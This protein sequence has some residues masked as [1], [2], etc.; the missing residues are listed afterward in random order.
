MMHP[1]I[2]APLS[3]RFV[4]EDGRFDFRL[5]K[6]VFSDVDGDALS[7]T[8]TRADG[9]PLPDWITVNNDTLRLQGRAPENF[10]GSLDVRV[11]AS[12]GQLTRSDVFSLAVNPVNDAPVLQSPL[13]DKTIVVNGKPFTIDIPATTFSDPDGDPL[14]FAATLA[15]GQPLPS[16]M[17]FDGSKLTGTAP[18]NTTAA[19]N[20]K[21]MANDG[22]LQNSDVFKV[23]FQRGNAMPD[24]NN[25]TGFN[26]S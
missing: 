2:S 3:D 13:A 11:T 4:N 18:W 17:S 21:I 9:S 8:V 24:A 16:W 22:T 1:S 5:Q 14:Q 12:D 6:S 23:T 10:N 25:D 7:F 19:I 15:N 26:I 20:V